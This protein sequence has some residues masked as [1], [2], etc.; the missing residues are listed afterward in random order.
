DEV[1][2]GEWE[3]L[4]F[5]TENGPTG[6]LLIVRTGPAATRWAASERRALEHLG[7]LFETLWGWMF[8]EARYR[9]VVSSVEDSLFSFSFAEDGERCYSFATRQMEALTGY[10]TDELLA[11]RLSWA[12]SVVF[13]DDRD[14]VAKH[15]QVLRSERESRL[16]YRIRT[17]QGR[18]RWLR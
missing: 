10:T 5:A 4:P 6:M 7:V 11:G 3:A 9:R 18:V 14:A 17:A 13:E 12:G 16:V 8:A 15:D 2:A 1:G